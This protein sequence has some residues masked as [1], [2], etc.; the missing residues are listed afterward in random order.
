LMVIRVSM[1]SRTKTGKRRAR[2][3]SSESLPRT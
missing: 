2:A 1:W 3:L